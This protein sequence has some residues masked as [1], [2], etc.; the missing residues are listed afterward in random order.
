MLTRVTDRIHVYRKI[1][2][3]VRVILY[4][5]LIIEDISVLSLTQNLREVHTFYL[6]KKVGK[7][8]HVL[9]EKKVTL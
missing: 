2:D 4:V 7:F 6:A 8:G 1:E 5:T 9:A 3:L